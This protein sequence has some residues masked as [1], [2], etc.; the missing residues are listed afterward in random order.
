[1]KYCKGTKFPVPWLAEVFYVLT[2]RVPGITDN[3][4]PWITNNRTNISLV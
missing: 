2:M 1:M 4:H 3:L